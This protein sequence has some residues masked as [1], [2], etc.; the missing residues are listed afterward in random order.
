MEI[1]DFQR[2]IAAIYGD[3]DAARGVAATFAWLVEEI[4]E[5]SRALRSGD[6]E[7]M[8]EEFADSLAWLVSLAVLC[9]VDLEQALSKYAG[10]CPK[11]GQRPCT[12]GEEGSF[13]AR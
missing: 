2:S 11:C 1:A 9:E 5:L 4:G 8:V 10:W 3:K 7:S 6:R 13:L 12:C